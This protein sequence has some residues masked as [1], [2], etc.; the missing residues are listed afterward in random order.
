M[1]SD[2]KFAI[3][4]PCYESESTITDTLRGIMAQGEGVLRR[5]ACV[6]I[7]DDVS[8]DKTVDVVRDVWAL[9]W[10][11]VKF[12]SRRKN[13]GEMINVNTAVTSL[14]DDVEWFLHM[15]GDN[16]PKPGWLQI[17]TDRCLAADPKVGI[18]CASYDVFD[19]DGHTETGEERPGA[20]PVLVKGGVESVRDTVRRGCWWHNSCGAIRVSAFRETGGLPPGMR[21]KGDWDFLLRLLA[22]GWDIEY[23]P[24]TLMR[25]RH[26]KASASAF[27]FQTHLDI[28]E[29]LQVIQKHAAKLTWSDILFTHTQYAW[30]LTRRAGASLYRGEFARYRAAV[31]MLLRTGF[32]CLSCLTA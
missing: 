6:V 10:P 19:D 13:V 5:V 22:A 17:I 3:T 9:A 20:V 24:R 31:R 2:C 26:H 32:N 7:A 27:A 25:Y 12:E 4:I 18:V 15:H 21:Q 30:V 8:P 29:S 11:P 14:P 1:T 23:V 16:I 28:E